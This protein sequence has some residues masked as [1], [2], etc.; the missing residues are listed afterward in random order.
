VLIGSIL[1]Q[2]EEIILNR[3]AAHNTTVKLGTTGYL[4]G[5]PG[6]GASR[7]IPSGDF[8][9]STYRY[10]RAMSCSDSE[11][12]RDSLSSP[13]AGDNVAPESS[14]GAMIDEIDE[15]TRNNNNIAK[16]TRPQM[17]T[18]TATTTVSSKQRVRR[19]RRASFTTKVALSHYQRLRSHLLFSFVN[20]FL[21]IVVGTVC[22]SY[23]EEKPWYSAYEH[24]ETERENDSLFRN[25]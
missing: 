8:D 14:V 25:I 18:T 12:E 13:T 9:W 21:V 19:K 20:L 11:L 7:F 4:T 22:F 6:H 16:A 17:N 2:E 3:L 5:I 10:D 24:K 23:L 15:T 1:D